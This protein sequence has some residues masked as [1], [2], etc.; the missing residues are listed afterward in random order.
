MAWCKR[1]AY[2]I[3][4][5]PSIDDAVPTGC[6]AP[7]PRE[8]VVSVIVTAAAGAALGVT[9]AGGSMHEAAFGVS[10]V[11]DTLDQDGERPT[12]HR[13]QHRTAAVAG[14]EVGIGRREGMRRRGRTH[15]CRQIVQCLEECGGYT[16]APCC[17]VGAQCADLRCPHP[18]YIARRARPC[19]RQ[20]LHRWCAPMRRRSDAGWR[21][22]K[23]RRRGTRPADTTQGGRLWPRRAR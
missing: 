17:Q 23:P 9:A 2:L 12:A 4:V 7:P 18:R 19:R 22:A 13:R 1:D 10:L 3:D 6:K 8:R 15:G 21:A 14:Q 5:R 16:P 20:L 11:E